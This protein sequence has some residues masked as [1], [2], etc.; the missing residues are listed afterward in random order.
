MGRFGQRDEEVGTHEDVQLGGVEAA[1]GLVE[2]REVQ[3]DEEVLGVLVDLRALVARG[4]VLVV[5]RMELEVLLEPRAVD[6][7]GPLDVDPPQPMGLDG[8]YVGL[9][10]AVSGMRVSPDTGGSA[11]A[12]TRDAWHRSY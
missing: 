5:E 12:W 9:R 11:E 10:A 6:R 7:A 8:L 2:H 4:H 3:D 1:H